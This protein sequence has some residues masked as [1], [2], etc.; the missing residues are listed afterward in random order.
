MKIN[1][2]DTAAVRERL[3]PEQIVRGTIQS[4]AQLLQGIHIGFPS[5]GFPSGQI[6]LSDAD[7]F[8]KL[9]LCQAFR[10]SRILNVIH[11]TTTQFIDLS[12]PQSKRIVK[13]KIGK[14][15]KKMSE[16]T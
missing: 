16:K 11:I 10:F 5:I 12:I 8:G 15:L 7:D 2:I 4:F 13:K 3:L 6:T 9:C 14:N 1:V